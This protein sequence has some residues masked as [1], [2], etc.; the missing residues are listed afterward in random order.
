MLGRMLR[1]MHT[2]TLREFLA[3]LPRGGVGLFAA[4]LGIASVYLS[5]IASR[6][7]GREAS[8]ELCVRIERASSG[9]VSRRDLRPNDW[10]LIWPELVTPEHPAPA[11][12]AGHAA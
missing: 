7:N 8:P 4:Q 10:H 1:T 9:I 5:Q 11:V 2:K 3:E 12:E 6:Q